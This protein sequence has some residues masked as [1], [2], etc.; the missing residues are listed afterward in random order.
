L[1]AGAY[2]KAK[3][4]LTEHKEQLALLANLLLEKEVMFK[5][6]LEIIIGKRPFE[7]EIATPV[8][9][10][11]DIYIQKAKEDAKNAENKNGANGTNGTHIAPPTTNGTK[12]EPAPSEAP[13]VEIKTTSAEKESATEE[14]EKENTP[15]TGDQPSLF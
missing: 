3:R 13:K 2:I 5:E 9:K 1:I 14:K 11:A 4:I 10:R 15:P 12:S 7:V 8:S 6:D